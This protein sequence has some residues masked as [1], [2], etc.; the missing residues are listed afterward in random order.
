MG[1]Y[2]CR[3]NRKDL[4]HSDEVFVIAVEYPCEAKPCNLAVVASGVRVA[5]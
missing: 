3:V 4:Q 2:V 5:I 1:Y